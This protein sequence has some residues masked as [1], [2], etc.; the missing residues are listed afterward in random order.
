VG[1]FVHIARANDRKPTSM[2]IIK[3]FSL[4]KMAS[5]ARDVLRFGTVLNIPIVVGEFRRAA[6][7]HGED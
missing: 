4:R 1:E 6:P 3:F 7:G 2:G 5:V